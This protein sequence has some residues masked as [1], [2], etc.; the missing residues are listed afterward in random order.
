MAPS[1][2]PVP[3][4]YRGRAVNDWQRQGLRRPANGQR[5]VRVDNDYLL[6]AAAS[7]LIASIVAASR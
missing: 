5:W 4:Q 3:A 1:R 7:G 2:R 6:V